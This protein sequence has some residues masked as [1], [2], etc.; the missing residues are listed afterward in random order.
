MVKLQ[1][2]QGLIRVQ[3]TQKKIL[4]AAGMRSI[5]RGLEI[6]VSRLKITSG[7]TPD[8]GAQLQALRAG[9]LEDWRLMMPRAS[10]GLGALDRRSA[11]LV[12][13]GISFI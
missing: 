2:L 5:Y 6:R 4:K 8:V 3:N 13:C 1:L 7:V 10:P 11:H 9:Q 12:D